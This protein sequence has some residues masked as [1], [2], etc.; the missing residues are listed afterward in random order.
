M[1]D[2]EQQHAEMVSA[3]AKPGEAILESLTPQRAHLWHMASCVPGEAGE[4]FDAVKK[5][6]IYGKP[7]D[8]ENVVEELGDIEFYLRGLRD[9]LG[10]TREE[11]LRSNV[12]KL[13]KRYAS[14][15]FSDAQA[16]QRADKA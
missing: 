2:L 1:N 13:G 16:Q 5:S 14:G 4:L 7:I 15:A 11:T 6:V 9:A 3:L 10:I 12:A 8:I